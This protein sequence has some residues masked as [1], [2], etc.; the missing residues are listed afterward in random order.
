MGVWNSFPEY[1]RNLQQN[2]PKDGLSNNA[3]GHFALTQFS[4]REDDGHFGQMKALAPSAELHFDLEG[5]ADKAN[6][7]KIDGL[8]HAT[9][10]A[11]EAR[12]GV[13]ETQR[14]YGR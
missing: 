9:A 8:Q 2:Y 14:P 1:A 7:L 5:V 11:L 6:F 10:V 3:A 13:V 4:V 12:R